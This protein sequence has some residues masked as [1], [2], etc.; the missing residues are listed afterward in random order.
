LLVVVEV[1]EADGVA[2]LPP[3]LITTFAVAVAV[4]LDEGAGDGDTLG[5]GEGL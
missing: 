1:V 2:A 5:D 4:A 3:L